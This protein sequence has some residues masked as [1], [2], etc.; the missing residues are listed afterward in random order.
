MTLPA[1]PANR[2]R[3]SRLRLSHPRFRARDMYRRD[4]YRRSVRRDLRCRTRGRPDSVVNQ[5]EVPLVRGE[6]DPMRW[7]P[8]EA[9]RHTEAG[10]GHRVQH[11][12]RRD[13]ADLKSE[14]AIGGGERERV[15]SIDREGPHPAD[16]TRHERSHPADDLPWTVRVRLVEVAVGRAAEKHVPPVRTDDRVMRRPPGGD[17]TNDAARAAAR[18]CHVLPEVFSPVGMKISRP[19]WLMSNESIPNR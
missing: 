14:V 16:P 13:V 9:R 11:P 6:S 1:L 2:Y 7:K 5:P 8:V 19:S 3:P 18:T 17:G 4:Q 15:P 12:T 10:H